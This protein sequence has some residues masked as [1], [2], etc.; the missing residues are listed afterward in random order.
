MIN[1]LSKSP[2]HTPHKNHIF[3]LYGDSF[4]VNRQHIC[5]YTNI[6]VKSGESIGKIELTF[7]LIDQVGFCCLLQ[8]FEGIRL[9]PEFLIDIM[10]DFADEPLKRW[11]REQQ[12]GQ[13][14]IP[15]DFTEGGHYEAVSNM[16]LK[17]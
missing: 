6:L 5:Y 2:A 9:E 17:D 14:L 10:C 13:L 16:Q 3:C 11:F 1:L 8:C 12:L 7:K 15:M 4:G